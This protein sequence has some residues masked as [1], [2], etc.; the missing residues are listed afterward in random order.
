MTERSVGNLA[1]D[2]ASKLCEGAP[3][4]C[5][6]HTSASEWLVILAIKDEMSTS[7]SVS[8]SGRQIAAA[9]ELLNIT[10]VELAAISGVNSITIARFEAGHREAR[11][12]T[13]QML[14]EALEQ[15]GIEFINGNN[16]GVR[17]IRDRTAVPPT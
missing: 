14:R 2:L 12:N 11:E 9:R 8:I 16:P 5:G 1:M 7:K 13:L 6:R 3:G 10:Q 15:Q 17:L 4:H